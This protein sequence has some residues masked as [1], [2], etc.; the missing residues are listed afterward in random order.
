[1][2]PILVSGFVAVLAAIVSALL[3]FLLS[4]VFALGDLGI[5]LTFYL[6]PATGALLARS[7]SGGD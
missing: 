7:K 4:G 6:A 3:A 5:A 1:M 2:A